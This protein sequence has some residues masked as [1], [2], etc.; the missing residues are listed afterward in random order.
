MTSPFK[1]L[2]MVKIPEVIHIFATDKCNMNCTYC[3]REHFSAPKSSR[4]L[5]KIAEILA[6]NDVKHVVIGGGEPT[7]VRNLDDVLKTLKKED[8]FVELHTNC[9]TLTREKLEHYKTE[10]LIDMAGIPIDSLDEKIQRQLRDYS[11]YT[12]LIKRVAKDCQDLDFEIVYHTVAT[13]LNISKVPALYNGF[14]KNTFFDSWKIYEL[15]EEL[16]RHNILR[17]KDINRYEKFMKLRGEFNHEKGC[18]DGLLAKFLL[19]E[20]KMQDCA[21]HR[22]HFVGLMDEK[23]SYLFINTAGDVT[24]YNHFSKERSDRLKIGNILAEKFSEII[25]NYD[26]IEENGHTGSDEDFFG[27][28]ADLPIFARL[29]EGNYEDE[30]IA[31]IKPKYYKKVE[32]LAN[33][34]EKRMF[35]EAKTKFYT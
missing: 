32:H 12:K 14:I 19:T 4:N 30:E 35:G 17:K 11:G 3:F 33:L 25:K 2:T 10:D 21:D 13:D 18:S 15:N 1:M 22:I 6:A 23:S 7:L 34:W 27:A 26:E 28:H 5:I 16:A 20:E 31:Q 24:Y 9:T 8:I 29:Y